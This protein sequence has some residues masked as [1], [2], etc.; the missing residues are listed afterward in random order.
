MGKLLAV[1]KVTQRCNMLC[2]PSVSPNVIKP[3]YHLSLN[4]NSLFYWFKSFVLMQKP[5]ITQL[6]SVLWKAE[7]S[8]GYYLTHIKCEGYFS[9]STSNCTY[10]NNLIKSPVQ[11]LCAC[12]CEETA[13]RNKTSIEL[14]KC[15]QKRRNL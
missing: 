15:S 9:Q 12:L 8:T 2:R 11:Y 4:R 14:D 1:I 6:T 5:F 7:V 13:I 10:Y 3:H